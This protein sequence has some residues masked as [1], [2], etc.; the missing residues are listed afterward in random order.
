MLV[1]MLVKMLVG[2]PLVYWVS[3]D[4]EMIKKRHYIKPLR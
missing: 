4:F 3:Q 1:E 2:S